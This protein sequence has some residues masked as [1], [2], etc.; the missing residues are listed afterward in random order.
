MCTF[1]CYVD[2]I[3]D[4]SA[5]LHRLAP[6]SRHIPPRSV[7]SSPEFLNLCLHPRHHFSSHHLDLANLRRHALHEGS[8]APLFPIHILLLL[9][10]SNPLRIL[11]LLDF[12]SRFLMFSSTLLFSLFTATSPL[13]QYGDVIGRHS[14]HHSPCHPLGPL[15]PHDCYIWDPIFPLL[16]HFWVALPSFSVISPRSEK[17]SIARTSSPPCH[18]VG[19]GL[20]AH[21]VR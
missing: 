5:Y 13:H 14:L 15:H 17:A 19:T 1:L 18:V 21:C 9:H 3:L 2:H 8:D 10:L 4:F 12:Q 16:C 7:P 20:T 6:P 11:F